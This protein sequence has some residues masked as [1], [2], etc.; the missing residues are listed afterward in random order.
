MNGLLNR[1][2]K[3]FRWIWFTLLLLLWS[4]QSY[5]QEIPY[6]KNI[7]SFTAHLK[8]PSAVHIS[9]KNDQDIVVVLDGLNQRLVSIS[10]Q[11]KQFIPIELRSGHR[12]SAP[13]DILA[14]R[15]GF[16]IA[17]TGNHR[18]VRLNS[19]GREQDQIDLNQWQSQFKKAPE[20][21][22]LWLDVDLLYWADRANHQIC[23]IHLRQKKLMRCFGRYGNGDGQLRFPY[24]MSED[25]DG[26]LYIVDVLNGRVLTFNARGR[27]F[28]QLGRFG[29]APG[30][31]FRPNGIAIDQAGFIYVSDSYL[32]RISVFKANRFIGYL[33][34]SKNEIVTFNS[35]VYLRISH[36]RL[37]VV[38]SLDNRIISLRIDYRTDAPNKLNRT[39]TKNS[40]KRGRNTG[41]NCVS[42]HLTWANPQQLDELN[43]PISPPHEPV[44]PVASEKMCYS[45]HHGVVVESRLAMTEQH[46]HPGKFKTRSTVNNN[47]K[48]AIDERFPISPLPHDSKQFLSCASCHTPHNSEEEQEVLYQDHQNA[49]LRVPNRRGDLC[50]RCHQSK[51]KKARITPASKQYYL[52][53]PLSLILSENNKRTNPQG[54]AKNL[55]HHGAQFHDEQLICQSCHQVHGGKGDDLLVLSKT[56]NKLC[57]TCHQAQA[58]KGKKQARKKGVHPVNFR[59]DKQIKFNGKMIQSIDCSTCHQVHDNP[60]KPALLTGI[61]KTDSNQAEIDSLCV[62]CHQRH[63][64]KTEEEARIKG[65]H[66]VTG[67]MQETVR[68]GQKTH[69]KITCLTCHSVHHGEE[70]TPALVQ[71]HINGDLCQNCHQHEVKV[72]NSPHDFRSDAIDD[73]SI[74]NHFQQTP[75]QSGVCGT[76]HRMH[77]GFKDERKLPVLYAAKMVL[78][79]EISENSLESKDPVLLKR[80]KLCMNCHQEKG[81]AEKTPIHWFSHPYQDVILRSDPKQMPLVQVPQAKTDEAKRFG[82]KIE[83]FG[84][85]ACITCHNPHLQN[86]EAELGKESQQH[87]DFLHQDGVKGTFCM[88]CH[89]IE[90]RIK[91]RYFHDKTMSRDCGVKYLK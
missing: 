75:Q 44:L 34:N 58:A 35:P 73:K 25:R 84:M 72:A 40:F 12:L 65:V 8:Q 27:F 43:I 71:N 83:E 20:P 86:R 90:A 77:G 11:Q 3:T 50:E 18:L 81:M 29:L 69:S 68:I 41:K 45:C 36:H 6:V 82:E 23:Q 59:L 74:A 38:D 52:N 10:G 15:D 4:S 32:G 17:D 28:S 19:Q 13:M 5:S 79:S 37:H 56:Q 57:D 60:G 22:S 67:E 55:S 64:A 2:Y 78:P 89:G 53:H 42:C 63:Y 30:E 51:G 91:Y 54:I 33:K 48:E 24:Q 62:Q 46:Q 1:S 26:Y 80:D 9:R 47:T 21:I 39:L 76:C 85:I 70:N 61:T 7:Q 88:S 66:P 14:I 87:P 16:W 31:L 49:W